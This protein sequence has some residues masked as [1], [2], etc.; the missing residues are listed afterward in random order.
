MDAEETVEERALRA[1]D[2]AARA[3]IG[4]RGT[5]ILGALNLLA[6]ASAPAGRQAPR[7]MGGGASAAALR[8]EPYWIR[9]ANGSGRAGPMQWGEL[10][11]VLAC[12]G[13]VRLRIAGY[14]TVELAEGQMA[15]FSSRLWVRP[16]AHTGVGFC[17]LYRSDAVA[18]AAYTRNPSS[19]ML[20][21]SEWEPPQPGVGQWV[22]ER[23][24]QR[25]AAQKERHGGDFVA[26]AMQPEA[27]APANQPMSTVRDVA[28]AEAKQSAL[29]RPKRPP[30]EKADPFA[31][32]KC[33]SAFAPPF[34]GMYMERLDDAR[35]GHPAVRVEYYEPDERDR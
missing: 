30:S 26:A 9:Y 4:D 16:L 2:R 18:R 28:I 13:D 25:E 20:E 1:A 8:D 17:L 35:R 7:G 23:E 24:K 10:L 3:I 27:W 5:P 15:I 21:R 11:A 22:R 32:Q 19:G 12:G 14:E 29:A 31:G 34:S 6:V 33:A